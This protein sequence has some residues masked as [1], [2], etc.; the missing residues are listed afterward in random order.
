MSVLHKSYS[1]IKMS[2]FYGTTDENRKWRTEPCQPSKQ[3]VKPQARI[4]QT[5]AC[6]RGHGLFWISTLGR[7]I[8]PSQV[9]PYLY[10]VKSGECRCMG[11]QIVAQAT[12]HRPDHSDQIHILYQWQ[13]DV[14]WRVPLHTSTVEPLQFAGR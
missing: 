10:M 5:A 3:P 11:F 12:E 6:Q 2:W 8:E 14:A 4:S 9:S 7:S 13:V 1:N